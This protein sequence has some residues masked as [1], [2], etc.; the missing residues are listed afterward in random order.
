MY[1]S[2][3]IHDGYHRMTWV[4]GIPWHIFYLA[5]SISCL[6]RNI[7]DTSLSNNESTGVYDILLRKYWK[8][9]VPLC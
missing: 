3:S 5:D 9:I 4:F 8:L 2:T 7:N 6:D 1:W